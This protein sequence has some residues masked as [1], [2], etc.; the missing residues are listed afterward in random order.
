[1]RLRIAD[2][3]SDRLRKLTEIA[4]ELNTGP[5]QERVRTAFDAHVTSLQSLL[6]RHGIEVQPVPNRTA[7]FERFL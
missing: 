2:D 5:G 6:D 3:E 4:E 7:L 1:L